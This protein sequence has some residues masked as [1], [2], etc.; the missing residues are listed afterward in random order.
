MWNDY[1]QNLNSVEVQRTGKFSNPDVRGIKKVV[2]DTDEMYA[3]TIAE[4]KALLRG[5]P[6]P[7]MKTTMIDKHL[8]Q[9]AVSFLG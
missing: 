2:T 1:W 3:I 7:P 6:I 5:N 4:M 8:V 9:V